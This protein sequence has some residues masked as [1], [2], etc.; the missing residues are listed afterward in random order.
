M[1]TSPFSAFYLLN[2]LDFADFMDY[3]SPPERKPIV[4][5]VSEVLLAAE[6]T[7]RGLHRRVAQQKLN[8]FQSAATRMA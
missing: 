5:R 3:F 4:H 8:L 6:V 2:R 1:F 7:F